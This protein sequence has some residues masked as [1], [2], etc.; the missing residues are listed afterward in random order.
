MGLAGVRA[1]Q[2]RPAAVAMN[3]VSVWLRYDPHLATVLQQT[4]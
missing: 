1:A 3:P 4:F 2:R